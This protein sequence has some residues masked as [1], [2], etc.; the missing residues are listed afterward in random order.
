MPRKPL[1]TNDFK[2]PLVGPGT[3]YYEELD[4]KSPLYLAQRREHLGEDVIEEVKEKVQRRIR[5]LR[6]V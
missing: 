6:G 3:C 2:L 5:T 4:M 1:K